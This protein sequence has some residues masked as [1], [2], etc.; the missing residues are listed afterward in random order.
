MQVTESRRATHHF[1]CDRYTYPMFEYRAIRDARVPY[2][3]LQ[4]SSRN[5]HRVMLPESR[6]TVISLCLR[7]VLAAFLLF[8]F[9][10]VVRDGCDAYVGCPYNHFFYGPRHFAFA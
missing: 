5:L 4:P 8:V 3:C 10:I 2:S 1:K 7:D 9:C 6:P